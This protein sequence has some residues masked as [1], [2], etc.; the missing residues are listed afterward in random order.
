MTHS[1]S[2]VDTEIGLAG[3]LE[4]LR[5]GVAATPQLRKGLGF[6]AG[7]AL[8]ASAGRIVIP[9]LIQLIL[10][11]GVGGPEGFRPGYVYA[12]SGLAVVVIAVVG[13]LNRTTY[14]R[15]VRT[16]ESS[17]C[18]LRMKAFDHIHRLSIAD[19][20]A[21][22]RGT[23]TARVT[24]DIEQLARFIQ[25]GALGWIIS[26]AVIV[27]TVAVML[28]YS[29]QLT[30]VVLAVYVPAIP[31]GRMIQRRQ[32]KAYDDLRTT[33]A[34]TLDATSEIVMGAAVVRSYGYRETAR[35]HM[36]QVI[37]RQYRSQLKSQRYFSLYLPV[38]EVFGATA[39][40]AAVGVGVWWGPGW[41]M[42]AGELVA[43][44][45][46]VN[47][48]LNPI[49]EITE[50][51]DQTQVALASWRKILG[52]LDQPVTVVDPVDGCVLPAGA[53]AVSANN[54]DFVYREGPQVLHD[55]SVEIPAGSRVAIVGETGSGKTTF[56][57]LLARL[58]DPTLGSVEVGGVD[59][60]T[61]DG[62]ARRG[63]IR[64]VPQDGFL[65]D[66]SVEANV[67]FGRDGASA[68]DARAAFDSLGLG[69]W[70][71]SL[72]DGLATAVGERGDDLSV[73][74]RQLV[75]LARAQLADP[76]LLI[77]DEATSAVDPETE[78]ALAVALDALSVGRT[79]VSIAHRL[80][81]AET[82]DMV[83]VFDSGEIV[84]RGHHLDLVAAG[85]IYAG[86]FESWLGNTQSANA[87]DEP[88][89]PLGG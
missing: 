68:A 87:P 13:L 3:A 29:W 42:S 4:V 5:R 31:Y 60:K 88:T 51:L 35:A 24:S 14:N 81:T 58:A 7:F 64:M 36:H 39:M 23:L 65:F 83:L 26:S 17:L 84:E 16:A 54:V 41:G 62:D 67:R 61:V 56:A 25:W 82:A 27:G 76:G 43:Y 6:T 47:M 44:L 52:V 80:S 71:E 40:A 78:Q 57:Q 72:R 89:M 77:L 70:I 63:A 9:I 28:V 59:L 85:G 15:L 46:L 50:V 37:N 22:R 12:A 33:V 20:N 73:G 32:L 1:E 38:T 86:L 74:E 2:R 69:S 8:T 66:T 34:D 11:R 10:D 19:H 49:T 75:A 30:I 45:F 21:T 53:L 18:E 55:V 48:L 79:T